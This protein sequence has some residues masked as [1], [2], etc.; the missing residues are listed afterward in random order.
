MNLSEMARRSYLCALRRGKTR[1]NNTHE[2]LCRGIQEEMDELHKA[3]R[4]NE[5]EHLK[6]ISEEVEELADVILCC[7]T[8]LYGRGL[9]VEIVIKRKL[10]FN[11]KRD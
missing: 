6:G 11:E 2:A 9:D 4:Y 7:M 10:L 3:D 5:S 8:E 1:R